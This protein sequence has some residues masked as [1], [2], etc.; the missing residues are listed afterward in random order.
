VFNAGGPPFDNKKLRQGIAHAID[1][2]EIIDAAFFGFGQTTDQKYPRGS[3]WYIEGI[4][5]VSYDIEKARAFLREAGY[6]GEPITVITEAGREQ[7]ATMAAIQAQLKR[8]G[9]DVRIQVAEYGAYRQIIERG[10]STFNFMGSGPHLDPGQTYGP[11]LHCEA[12]NRKR[13]SNYSGYCNREVHALLEKAETE[14]NE[15]ARRQIYKEA[16]TR[17]AD[18]VPIL[19]VT[20]VPRFFTFRDYVKGFSTD[21]EGHFMY[22]GGGLNYTWLDK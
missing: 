16:L 17:V 5:T 20:F 2:K 15:N 13:T 11:E 12:D 6:N 10:D 3:K 14:L 18:D 21:G 19:P 9:V 7:E 8:V 22:S 1:K 4:P